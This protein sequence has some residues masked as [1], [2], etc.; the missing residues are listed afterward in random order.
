MEKTKLP[1]EKAK[2]YLKNSEGRVSKAIEMAE[3]QISSGEVV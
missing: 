3:N 2:Q 1:A